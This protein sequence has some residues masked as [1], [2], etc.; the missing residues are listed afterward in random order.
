MTQQEYIQLCSKITIWNHE[1][2]TLNEPS[3]SDE[4]YD[5]QLALLQ[6]TEKEHPEWVSLD[7]PANKVGG[8]RALCGLTSQQKM[9]SADAVNNWWRSCGGGALVAEPKIDGCTLALDY[10]EGKLVKASLR[11]GGNG[12]NDV[13]DKAKFIGGVPMSID[14]QK[15]IQVRGE[16]YMPKSMFETINERQKL[17]GGKPYA[18]PRNLCAGTMQADDAALCG[19]RGLRFKA[20]GFDRY[21]SD[22][23]ALA[24]I[25]LRAL[26]FDTTTQYSVHDCS[27]EH[28]IALIS[29]DKDND[30]CDYPI[31]G[32]VF[33]INDMKRWAEIGVTEHHPKYMTAYKFKTEE[34]TVKIIDLYWTVAKSGKI[35]PNVTFDTARLHNTNVN[36]ATLNNIQWLK[37]NLGELRYGDEVI[38]TKGGEIIPKVI[39]VKHNHFGELIPII[40]KCPMC[41]GPITHHKVKDGTYGKEDFCDNEECPSRTVVRTKSGKVAADQSRKQTVSQPLPIGRGVDTGSS[42]SVD[43]SEDA[44]VGK[45]VVVS[46]TFT[47]EYSRSQ[48]ETMVS[49]AGGKLASS[50]SGKTAFIVAGEGM[51]P[52]KRE[53]A[54]KLGVKIISDVEFLEMIKK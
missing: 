33:K 24:M 23:Y 16:V 51:G 15:D 31:D 6:K 7:S 3:V 53:K 27:V 48:L 39:G 4:Y 25:G 46:G 29:K 21:D 19:E 32:I 5:E 42:V 44:L 17:M 41:G 11:D 47:G 2:Y 13:T 49:M 54:L 20:W 14:Y 38:V 50:V 8:G 28:V 34:S 18:N 43:I 9:F 45:S 30:S 52:S 10:H 40:D 1:Y 12:Q 37:D 36:H 26:G 22:S 35:T